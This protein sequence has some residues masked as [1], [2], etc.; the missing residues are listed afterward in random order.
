MAT[1]TKIEWTDHTFNPWIGC[2]KVHAG[3]TH[4]YAESYAKR[5][6]KAQWG[7]QGT[8]VKTS[9]S[10]WKQPLKWEANAARQVIRARREGVPMPER[11]RVFCAS[12]AD[13]FEDWTDAMQDH[14]CEDLAGYQTMP[15]VRRDLFALIDATPHL[16]WLLLTKR[17]ENVRTMYVPHLLEKVRGH[18]SQNEG[19]GYRIRQRSNVWIGTSI[20]DQATADEYI[21]RLLQLRDL[22]PVLF[23]SVEP[24]LGPVDLGFDRCIPNGGD[25]HDPSTCG[26]AREECRCLLDWVIVGGESGHNARPC[27]IAW[28]R[29]IVGQCKAAGVPCFV[30]QLGSQPTGDWG[31]GD[32]PFFAGHW[33]LRDSKGGD[34]DEWPEDLRVRHFPEVSR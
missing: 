26:L 10:Y 8:R 5:Y 25:M 18:V 3:C 32:R 15:D 23:L 16:D 6:G 24:L 33:R 1:E 28:I 19:D 9:E 13:V 27:N 31:S 12:L 7:P 11:P 2:T 30:K 34:P 20:S 22:T 17:P 4:C 21:P 29:S 14:R